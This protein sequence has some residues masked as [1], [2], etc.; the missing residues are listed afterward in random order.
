[1][2]ERVTATVTVSARGAAC[3]REGHPWVRREAE[4]AAN[5]RAA[6]EQA[7]LT[8]EG[9]A[10]AANLS[11]NQIQLLERGSNGAANPRL[12]TLYAIAGALGVAVVDLLPQDA[13]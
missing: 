13:R 8:Q 12:K 6:R 7:S 2:S 11:R 4:L 5:L 3:V 10:F 1:M 9:L